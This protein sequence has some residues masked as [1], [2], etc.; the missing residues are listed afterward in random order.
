MNHSC[1]TETTYDKYHI[2]HNRGTIPVAQKQP[3]GKYI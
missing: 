2:G 3:Y 1:R